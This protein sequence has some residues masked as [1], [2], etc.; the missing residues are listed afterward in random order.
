MTSTRLPSLP[1]AARARNLLCSALALTLLACGD[2]ASE[3][4]PD[5]GP[6]GDGSE[7]PDAEPGEE[8]AAYIVVTRVVNP[9]GRSVYLSVLPSLDATTIDLS[10]AVE[11]SGLS[12]A[13]AYD[14]AVFI[15]DGETGQ[16]ARN[17]V[18]DE[19]RLSETARFS[20]A[21][22]GITGF[23]SAFAFISPTR[24]YYIDAT[25]QQ[26]VVWNPQAM[27]ITGTFDVPELAREDFNTA[28]ETPQVANGRVISAI[29]WGNLDQGTFHPAVG[30]LVL[31]AEADKLVG[32]FEDD[33]CAIGGGGFFD[34]KGDFYVIGDTSNGAYEAF[35]PDSVPDAC[36]LRLPAG[37]NEFDPDFVERM[38]DLAENPYFS[39]LTGT[40]DRR[41][42]TRGFDPEFDISE[43]K[44]SSEYLSLKAWR[45]RLI[46][47][48]GRAATEVALPAHVLS[49]GPFSVDDGFLLT[50]FDED[51]Q[52]TQLYRLDG[53]EPV[54]SV[55]TPGEIQYAARIR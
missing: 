31:D 22:L 4:N 42:L 27:E 13:F 45:W 26:V 28:V 50:Q 47:L 44:D 55:T 1:R 8:S 9:D 10:E 14:G 20:M 7:D 41:L 53:D 54:E 43:V 39:G 6:P 23:S 52:Q 2:D 37:A 5:G 29:G 40:A 49:F 24:A 21:N 33:R 30:L 19:R 11:V 25:N 17:E 3:D 38:T 48:D 16:I 34:D 32:L 15:M 46:D 36:L 35:G 18:D 51:A 12:R